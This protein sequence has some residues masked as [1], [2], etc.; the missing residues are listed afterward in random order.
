M[1]YA[2][3]VA[4]VDGGHLDLAEQP[5]VEGDDQVP[6]VDDGPVAQSKIDAGDGLR[7]GVVV[8][9]WSVP[10]E[11]TGAHGRAADP[12]RVTCEREARDTLGSHP[13]RCCGSGCRVSPT[14]PPR[15]PPRRRSSPTP[16]YRRIR[17]GVVAVRRLPA[18][19]RGRVLALARGAPWGSMVLGDGRCR[20]LGIAFFAAAFVTRAA[21]GMRLPFDVRRRGPVPISFINKLGPPGVGSNLT[22]ERYFEHAQRPGRRRWRPWDWPRR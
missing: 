20:L 19:G 13:Q 9:R 7:G 8:R 15:R 18:G 10:G 17:R 21:V 16:A 12:R 4:G 22:I 1:S 3:R 11:Y 2:D 6:A 5:V 14:R